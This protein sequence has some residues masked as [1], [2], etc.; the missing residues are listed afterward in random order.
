MGANHYNNMSVFHIEACVVYGIIKDKKPI[1]MG[2]RSTEGTAKILT[3][4]IKPSMY[5]YMHMYS[6]D[7]T[8]KQ[9]ASTNLTLLIYND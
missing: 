4:W 6:I 5:M 8:I 2:E 1:L 7:N 3:L 9:D